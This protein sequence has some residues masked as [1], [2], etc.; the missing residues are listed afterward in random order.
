MTEH[1]ARLL[2]ERR[3]GAMRRR[4]AA[5]CKASVEA[6]LRKGPVACVTPDEIAEYLPQTDDPYSSHPPCRRWLG[7]IVGGIRGTVQRIRSGEIELEDPVWTAE[8]LHGLTLSGCLEPDGRGHGMNWR[9][10]GAERPGLERDLSEMPWHKAVSEPTSY[11][12]GRG[13][14]RELRIGQF[15]A[16]LVPPKDRLSPCVVA[17]CLAGVVSRVDKDG[18]TS[19]TVKRSPEVEDL[20]RLWT[21][22]F[23][24][25]GRVLLLSPFYAALFSPR[26]PTHIQKEILS[27][28][29]P[30]GCPV[31]P[32]V[33]WQ[34][35]MGPRIAGTSGVPFPGAIPWARGRVWAWRHGY[36]L[37]SMRYYALLTW[38]ITCVYSGLREEMLLWYAH[39]SAERELIRQATGTTPNEGSSSSSEDGGETPGGALPFPYPEPL[40]SWENHPTEPAASSSSS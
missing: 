15:A 39:A 17:G 8:F 10:R 14:R 25:K 31:L 4:H 35:A 2:D 24:A 34:M 32:T 11:R 18:R 37:K 9:I 23:V 19:H 3:H 33:L 12:N 20:L 21:I 6:L 26:M 7:R 22:H 40:G 29:R 27:I 38:K 30:A 1:F 13:L 16:P 28:K 5:W 36:N